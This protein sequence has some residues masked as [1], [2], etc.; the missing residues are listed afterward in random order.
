[1]LG[2]ISYISPEQAQGQKVDHRSDIWSLGV[3]L[4]EMATGELPFSHEYDAAVVYSILDK[5][6]LPPTEIREDLPE[7]LER[8]IYRC[9]RKRKEE[10]IQSASEL[11]HELTQIR[12]KLKGGRAPVIPCQSPA[13]NRPNADLPLCW[14]RKLPAMVSY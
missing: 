6:P 11:M 13:R 14:F 4:Y 5:S 10:R 2:T 3:V 7:E 12:E 9:L 1:A 8:T